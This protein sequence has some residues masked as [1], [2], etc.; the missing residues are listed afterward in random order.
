MKHFFRGKTFIVLVLVLCFLL[1]FLLNLVIDGGKMPHRELFGFVTSPVRTG[2]SWCRGQV[3]HFF[4]TI[5]EHETLEAE[6]EQLRQQVAELR[7]QVSESA[8]DRVQNEQLRQLLSIS[9]PGYSFEYVSA[10]VV[11]VP[12]DGWNYTFGINVG[13]RAGICKGQVVVSAGG[14][15]GKVIDVGV[16]WATVSG[17]IDPQ[18]SVGAM[19]LSS[20]DVGI[21]EGTLALKAEG[22]CR[23]KYLKRD[24]VVNRGDDVYTSGLGGLYPKGIPVG[25]VED[26]S[27]EDNGLTL[28]AVIRPAVDFSGLKEVFVITNF[29]EGEE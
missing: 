1:G 21:T 11:S 7:R 13:T 10:D 16:N 17:F 27:Y 24:A 12:A 26:L 6:N 9:D 25:T 20:G 2:I 8:Y 15:V 23:L 19:L 14:L 5:S 28:T 29:A 18:I 3:T 22:L 4:D